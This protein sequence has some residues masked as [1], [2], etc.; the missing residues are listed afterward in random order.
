MSEIEVKVANEE[1]LKKW[2]EFVDST[3]MGTI[4]HKINWLRAAESHTKSKFYPLIGYKGEE[5]IAIFPIFYIRKHF[6]KM[7]FSPPP[8]CEI[9]YLGPIFINIEKMNQIK[10]ESILNNFI[11]S[12]LN[13]FINK[14]KPDYCNIASPPGMNDL[15][16]FIWNNFRVYPRYDYVVI[17]EKPNMLINDFPRTLRQN[18]RKME[19]EDIHVY[20]G[21]ID[22]VKKIHQLITKRYEE[23]N[24]KFPASID[25]LLEIYRNFSPQNM[26][27][28]VLKYKGNIIGGVIKL[29]YKK[30]IFD[31][32]GN[33]KVDILRGAPNDFLHFNIIKWAYNE[34]LEKYNLIGANTKRLLKF[35]KKYNPILELSFVSEKTNI[36][37]LIGR[38][39]YRKI[40]SRKSFLKN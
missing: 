34:G 7:V 23:Q 38:T 21:S 10:I 17:I 40:L 16:S 18:I 37:G 24:M 2:D 12:S 36:K 1:E 39:L 14:L 25:Y 13:F 8:K 15:R 11:E 31:W 5:L 6:L 26:K 33:P 22:D 19:K 32:I 35:K 30:I 28:F 9:P 27:T 3:Q 4:F 20:I 29:I